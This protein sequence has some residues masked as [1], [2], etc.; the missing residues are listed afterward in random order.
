LL[1]KYDA[2]LIPV[3]PLLPYK[4]N[5][6]HDP[7]EYEIYNEKGEIQKAIP[8]YW[9]QIA[10]CT[11]ITTTGHPVVTLPIGMAN[12]LPIGI[13][14]IGRFQDD[15]SLLAISA[16][17]EEILMEPIDEPQLLAYDSKSKL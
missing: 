16:V 2:W 1:E 10:L 15:E 13:Q 3:S 5:E 11:P 7:I 8:P 9:K 17:L 6:K 12:H 4:H 14:V